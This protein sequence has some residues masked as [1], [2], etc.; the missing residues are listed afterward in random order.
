MTVVLDHPV[1]GRWRASYAWSAERGGP[2]LAVRRF[3]KRFTLS[4]V[5]Q[6]FVVHVSADS[7]YRLWVN[8]ERVGRGPLKGTLQRYYYETYDLAPYLR[9]GSNVIAAEVRWFGDHTPTSEVHSR[10]PGFLFQGPE[11]AALDTPGTWR[12]LVDRAIEPDTTPYISNAHHFLGHWE[13]VDG[14][15]Y[16]RGW[17]AIDYDDAGWEPAVDTGPADFPGFWGETHPLQTLSPRD[18]PLLIEE[19][20]RFVRTLQ[21]QQEREHLFG[22]SPLGWTLPAGQADEIVLD[23]GSLTT[24]YP[25][26]VFDGGAGRRVEVIYGECIL[27]WEERRGRQVPVKGIRDDVASGVV[28]GY[29]DTIV[30]P[31]G[32]FRYEPFHWRTFWFVRIAVSAGDEPFTLRDVHYRFTTYPQALQATFEASIPDAAAM[33][34]V[35]WR[36]LQRCAHETYEDCPYYEQLNYVADSRLQ[37]LCSMVLAGESALPKRTIRL[38]H[39]SVRPDGLVHSR[40]PSTVPQILPYFA[41]IWTLMVEDYWRWV[42]PQDRAFVRSTLNVVDGVLWFFRERLRENG[43]VG[44]IPPWSMVDR[45]PGWP[46]GEPPA[47]AAGAST[48]LTCLYIHALDAAV[49]LHV[50]AGDPADAERWR[51]LAE[52]LRLAVREGAWS[53]QEGLFLEGPGRLDDGLSQHSQAL[54]ILSGVATPAQAQRI[55]ERLTTDPSLYRMKFMQSFY[56][57]RALEKA[58]GYAAF[59]PHVLKLWRKALAN[60]VST[61]PEYPDPT[62]SDCHAWSSW[63]AADF[64]TCVLGIQPLKPGFAEIGIAP[65]T[66]VGTYARG[67]APTPFGAV[68]VEWH[69]DLDTSRARLQATVPEG[70]PV[71]VQV[72]GLEP[73]RYPAGGAIELQW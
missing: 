55:L 28:D 44:Q 52:R 46:G 56:L 30:L 31:G 58:G 71:T 51:P 18:V 11:G 49:R 24:G 67:S 14:A 42:G 45:V 7:R 53:E 17:T 29:R 12:V 38:F 64:V 36:S 66:E 50:E 48:Y 54:A 72:P 20:R 3:R 34:E 23:A 6:Q 70:V 13:R 1:E 8:G 15:A 43:F 22:E 69:K 41:L 65:H 40:V 16:P 33:W 26:L 32:E 39:D 61:W 21:E 10:R 19:P 9:A 47:I 5:P 57:A 62:R 63:I 37:A 2:G 35:S 60:H 25:E 73:V 68:M 59:G 27:R 4:S